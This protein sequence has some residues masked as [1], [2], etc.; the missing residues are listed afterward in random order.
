[1]NSKIYYCILLVSILFAG[2]EKDFVSPEAAFEADMTSVTVGQEINFRVTGVG[3]YWAFWPGNPGATGIQI[4]EGEFTHT[5]F[6]PGVH[7]A[8]LI[9]SNL[10]TDGFELSRDSVFIDITVVDDENGDHT[11]FLRYSITLRNV[12]EGF[13]DRN[14]RIPVSGSI[15]GNE[16]VINVP[17][18]TELD[19]LKAD[20]DIKPSSEALI[21]GVPQKAKVTANDFS[22]PLSYVIVASDGTET[23]NTVTAVRLPKSDD[24]KL[25][26]F[27]LTGLP[28]SVKK[29]ITE[30]N[31]NFTVVLSDSAGV[32][33]LKPDFT[34]HN[35]ARAYLGGEEIVA[36]DTPVDFTSNVNFEVVAEDGTKTDYSVELLFASKF[37]RFYFGSDNPFVGEGTIN[38]TRDTLFVSAPVGIDRSALTASFD[39]FPFDCE[40]TVD[41]Q[42][43]QSG[44]TV[45]DFTSPVTFVLTGETTEEIVVVIQ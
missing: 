10:N 24:S 45:N 26:A 1:M 41:G 38:A 40:V 18:S 4:T 25:A 37:D 17:F 19:G 6:V 13:G 15:D 33:S 36:G 27:D 8:T 5:Y 7:R 44:V 28:G 23:V 31:N 29:T 14:I 2:C 12:F 3:E 16:V 20:F 32:S 42:V 34:I 39:T 43:Q 22:N 9:A 11:R 30:E 35:F 21:D